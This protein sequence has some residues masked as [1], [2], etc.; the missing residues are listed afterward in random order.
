MDDGGE[1]EIVSL[2]FTIC[3]DKNREDSSSERI[4]YILSVLFSVTKKYIMLYV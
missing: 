3:Y 1:E 2:L 4:N